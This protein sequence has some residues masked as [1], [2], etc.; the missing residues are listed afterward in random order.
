VF[1]WPAKGTLPGS[2]DQLDAY[3]LGPGDRLWFADTFVTNVTQGSGPSF[4][5]YLDTHLRLVRFPLPTS[6]AGA[7]NPDQCIPISLRIG[8]DGILW[9]GLEGPGLGR[10][11]PESVPQ[12]TALPRSAIIVTA[13]APGAAGSVWFSA[14]GA[15][16]GHVSRAG[17]VNYIVVSRTRTEAYEDITAASNGSLWFTVGCE[18]GIGHATATGVITITHIPGTIADAGDQ[19]PNLP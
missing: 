12:I 4:V 19:C 16:I 10:M 15:G 18:N 3:A 14:I 17:Q 8:T 5:G 1:S 11:P 7:C 13:F 9:F 2:T 6:V